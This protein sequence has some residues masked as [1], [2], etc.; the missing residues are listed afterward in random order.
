MSK[1]HFGKLTFCTIRQNVKN[2]NSCTLST[3][4]TKVLITLYQLSKLPHVINVTPIYG[5]RNIIL[6]CNS[7]G[8]GPFGVCRVSLDFPDDWRAHRKRAKCQT[9]IR[10]YRTYLPGVRSWARPTF[11]RS[12][13]LSQIG[14]I[15]YITNGGILDVVK[16]QIITTP[17]KLVTICN[18]NIKMISMIINCRSYIS[19]SQ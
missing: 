2:D 11:C 14:N 10:A 5:T 6:E 9:K 18:R 4:Y 8:R 19:I 1:L 16:R 3:V 17:W 15:N 7:V 12:L 13:I